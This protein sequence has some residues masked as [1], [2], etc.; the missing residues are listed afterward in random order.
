M[1]FAAGIVQADIT[2]AHVG[3]NLEARINGTSDKIVVQD[4]YL[5]NQYHVEE[6]RFNDGSILTDSQ[7]Q[8]LVSAMAGFSACV[9][10]LRRPVPRASLRG[11]R[12]LTV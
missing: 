12:W 4:W 1:Q 11:R 5:G 3:N 9:T 2:Y 10:A 6:F 8:G 7:V